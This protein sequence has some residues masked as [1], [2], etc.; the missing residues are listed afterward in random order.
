MSGKQSS[1]AV[2]DLLPL[3]NQ[4]PRQSRALIPSSYLELFFL[5][6][7]GSHDKSESTQLAAKKDLCNC[8]YAKLNCLNSNCLTKLEIEILLILKLCTYA[9]LNCL[10][11]NY[12]NFCSTE[13]LEIGLFLTSKQYT[14]AKLNCLK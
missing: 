2:T 7:F 1:V 12:L 14:Y 10:K 4:C 9:K 13:F 5:A 11:Q 6:L 8:T 3:V